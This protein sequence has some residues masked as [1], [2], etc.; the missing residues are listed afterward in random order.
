LLF[1]LFYWC[2][3]FFFRL[4]ILAR[5]NFLDLFGLFLLD[6]GWLRLFL[7]DFFL[8]LRLLRDFFFFLGYLSWYRLQWSRLGSL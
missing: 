1:R 3:D 7:L 4:L 6:R 8:R 5:R 2:L